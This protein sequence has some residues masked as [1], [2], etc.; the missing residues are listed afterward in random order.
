MEE[1]NLDLN[2]LFNLFYNFEWL[3]ILLTNI[4][5]DQELMIIKIKELEKNTK[6]NNN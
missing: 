4:E 6:E 3:K 2:N 1:I 5:K